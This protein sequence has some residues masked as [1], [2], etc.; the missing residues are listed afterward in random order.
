MDP[1]INE[2]CSS[3]IGP[4]DIHPSP[5]Q[6][7]AVPTFSKYA[8]K[9]EVAD[10]I[11]SYQWELALPGLSQQNYII[12]APTGTGKTLVAGLIISEHLQQCQHRGRV[13]FIV[14]KVPLARQ[15]KGAL[16]SMIHGA[17][18]EEVTGEVAQS[19]KAVLGHLSPTTVEKH[20]RRISDLGADIVVSTAGCFFNK[21][22][23]QQIEM[24]D[25][26]LIII[27]E[28]HH[29]HK[30]TDY[31]KIMEI[32][33]QKKRKGNESKLPQV[34]GLTASPGAG[35][36][37]NPS[38]ISV[39]NHLI[40]LCAHMD[41]V[42]GIKVVTRNVADLDTHT[43]KPTSTLA[44]VNGR[45]EN[46]PLI[47]LTCQIMSHLEKM[48]QLECTHCKW[49]QQYHG[50]WIPQKETEYLRTVTDSARD[51]ISTC[52]LLKCL[53]KAMAVYMDLT[54]EDM[55]EVLEEFSVAKGENATWTERKLAETMHQLKTKSATFPRVENPLLT[56]LEKILVQQFSQKPDSIAILFVETKKQATGLQRWVCSTPTLSNIRSQVVTGQTRDTGLK[57][58]KAEQE[59]A[60]QGFRDSKH[61]LLITTSVLEEGIDVPACNLVIRYQTVSNEIA[62]VQTKGRARATSSQTFTVIS[63]SSNKKYQELLNEE[64]HALVE[65]ALKFFP[66]GEALRNNLAKRQE[67]ILKST[68][69]QEQHAALHRE[70]HSAYEAELI[71]RKCKTFVCNG[72][73][74]HT[75]HSSQHYVVTDPEFRKRISIK[76]HHSPTEVPHG[77]SRTHKIYCASCG[78]D[79]GVMGR[80]WKDQRTL[81]VLKCTSFLFQINKLTSWSCKKWSQVPF[82]ISQLS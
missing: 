18:I 22:K 34:V 32:Y 35:E 9:Q 75:F 21:L 17:H 63:T 69:A 51:K 79:W 66:F 62:Q 70:Q 25:V 1:E 2:T 27:D 23:T 38:L 3:L 58:T 81:P 11:R 12:C 65:D 6:K 47:A 5:T 71:C 30:N 33:L 29:T 37:S 67:E 28:C 43:N 72:S 20:E 55:L 48:L 57:M 13:L 44:V 15:Q 45:D 64:K 77:M 4:L 46:E 53:S 14:N 60:I 39:R 50:N 10:S 36:G 73:D 8:L 61:N 78:Q 26:T 24:S 41:A 59:K 82:T 31:A 42:G 16:E 52:D 68:A 56:G 74:V 7:P 19:R 76:D 40:S 49:S 80:W 54:Y